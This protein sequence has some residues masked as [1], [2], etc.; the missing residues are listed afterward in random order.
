MKNKARTPKMEPAQTTKSSGIWQLAKGRQDT[1]MSNAVMDTHSMIFV[2]IGNLVSPS[3]SVNG[4]PLFDFP[5]HWQPRFSAQFSLRRTSEGANRPGPLQTKDLS[6]LGC[7]GKPGRQGVGA[8]V[9]LVSLARQDVYSYGVRQLDMS[10][11]AWAAL[12]FAGPTTGSSLSSFS[13]LTQSST[14]FPCSPPR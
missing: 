10:R 1:T 7:Q 2:T 4:D 8:V 13:A 6:G 9:S 12:A 3:S 11:P 14:S 5:D